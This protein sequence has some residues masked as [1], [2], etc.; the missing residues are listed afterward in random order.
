[1]PVLL[2][3]SRSQGRTWTRFRG[4]GHIHE[5]LVADDVSASRLGE[6]ESRFNAG[7][8]V[9][10]SLI[11]AFYSETFSFRAFLDRH[12]DQRRS[13]IDCLVGDVFKDMS[14]FTTALDSMTSA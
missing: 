3:S 9:I 4:S 10:G 12:P 5:A 14:A 7:I 8:G 13:L 11:G 1:M 2:V 6:F